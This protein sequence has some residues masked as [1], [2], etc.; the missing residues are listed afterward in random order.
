[1]PTIPA[2][3][4]TLYT[5]IHIADLQERLADVRG[6]RDSERKAALVADYER[7]LEEIQ[8]TQREELG[9]EQAEII[10]ERDEQVEEMERVCE[11]L[12]GR[13]GWS[14]R[15]SRLIVLSA[16]KEGGGDIDAIALQDGRWLVQI[17]HSDRIA[18]I[19]IEGGELLD[20]MIAEMRSVEALGESTPI[21]WAASYADDFPY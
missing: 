8:S 3:A 14:V 10:E 19:H 1:M 20:A 4:H 9:A 16:R 21:D 2:T 11:D 6:W 7:Q 5:A 13:A 17:A 15:T 12:Q 18:T